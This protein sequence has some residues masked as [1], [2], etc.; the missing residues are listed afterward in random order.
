[1]GKPRWTAAI[2]SAIGRWMRHFLEISKVVL[3]KYREYMAKRSYWCYR[4]NN[5]LV[6]FFWNELLDKRL[7]QGWDGLK[8]RI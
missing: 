8:D 5:D 2:T 4:I 3:T 7:R 6:D 1:M